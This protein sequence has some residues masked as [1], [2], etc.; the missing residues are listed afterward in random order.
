MQRQN[1]DIVVF[2]ANIRLMNSL[3][4]CSCCYFTVVVNKIPEGTLAGWKFPC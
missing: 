3:N 1:D 4:M 2:T